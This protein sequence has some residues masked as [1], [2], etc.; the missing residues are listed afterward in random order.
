M[1]ASA[2]SCRLN[3]LLLLS[4]F[5]AINLE[6][7]KAEDSAR[8]IGRSGCAS[9]TCHGGVVG[10]GPAWNS[11]FSAWEAHDA[12]H[13][14]AGNLLLNQQSRN[15]VARLLQ[16]NTLSGDQESDRSR[17]PSASLRED[18]IQSLL[19]E[20]CVSCHAPAASVSWQPGLQEGV[21]CESCHGPASNWLKLHTLAAPNPDELTKSGKIATKNWN[22]RTEN[23]T[24]CHVGSRSADG[25]IRDMNHDMIAAGH[26]A[27]WFDMSE[28]Q[29]SLPAHW[30]L[31][32]SKAL[33]KSSTQHE[34]ASLSE[35][36]EGRQRTL[37][38]A[39]NLSLERQAANATGHAPF[40]ELAEYNC[41]ACHQSIG[42]TRSLSDDAD[43]LAW[44]H[45]LTN[46]PLYD[47]FP[48]GDAQFMTGLK[49]AIE[50][51]NQGVS[52]KMSQIE[53]MRWAAEKSVTLRSR[54]NLQLAMNW[55]TNNELVLLNT[56]YRSGNQV[57]SKAF[58][59]VDDSA[60]LATLLERYRS[61]LGTFKEQSLSQP[62]L[63]NSS[64]GG[65]Q[66]SYKE[67]LHI[68][69]EYRDRIAAITS[70]SGIAPAAGANQ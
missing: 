70:R 45:L 60:A 33:Q 29:L 36:F 32:Q 58:L 63:V 52:P 8:Y 21:S 37:M 34:I 41:I 47:Q 5:V 24:R 12:A 54:P 53:A 64:N 30:Q 1:L 38:A 59:S 40:P 69:D 31:E 26:P 46:Q 62:L 19:K 43:G 65:E 44:N 56:R 35:H 14:G 16:S 13:S 42:Q 10:Q 3:C 25:V 2:I 66:V 28:S 4:S 68:R 49:Q 18:A 7:L 23:C 27:L 67:L 48:L 22:A 57:S 55:L 51:S 39:A 9:A 61:Q 17:G 11:S 20:R 50:N 6:P 15:I